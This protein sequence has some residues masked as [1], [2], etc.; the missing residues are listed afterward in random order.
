[1]DATS[2]RRKSWNIEA[3]LKEDSCMGRVR[4]TDWLTRANR[5]LF[6]KESG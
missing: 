6:T 4:F 1:M 2:L 3:T 5:K